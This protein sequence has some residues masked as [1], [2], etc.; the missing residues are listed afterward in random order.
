MRVLLI[1]LLAAISYAQT[2]NKRVRDIRLLPAGIPKDM[3]R[4]E[5]TAMV[6]AGLDLNKLKFPETQIASE[7]EW[8]YKPSALKLART[9]AIHTK[10]G[11]YPLG[12]NQEEL[13]MWGWLRQNGYVHGGKQQRLLSKPHKQQQY[14]GGYGGGYPF[15]GGKEMEY[16]DILPYISQITGGRGRFNY[17]I[18]MEEEQLPFYYSSLINQ[19]TS[20]ASSSNGSSTVTTGTY[21]TPGYGGAATGTGAASGAMNPQTMM[22]TAKWSGEDWK[23]YNAYLH[24]MAIDGVD[25]GELAQYQQ[26]AAMTGHDISR[27]PQTVGYGGMFNTFAGAATNAFAG[28][29]SSGAFSGAASSTGGVASGFNTPG[30]AGIPNI[31][32]SVINNLPP[33]TIN[34]AQAY[35]PMLFMEPEDQAQYYAY[36]RGM[37]NS[38]MDQEELIRYAQINQMSGGNPVHFRNYPGYSPYSAA[39]QRSKAEPKL[40]RPHV[41]E[42]QQQMPY[43]GEMEGEDAIPYLIAANA[44]RNKP[45]ATAAVVDGVETSAQD[46]PENAFVDTS[47]TNTQSGGMNPAMM[48]MMMNGES[49]IGEGDVNPMMM[50]QIMN[51]WQQGNAAGA[52][53]MAMPL[54]SLLFGDGI[55]EEMLPMIMMAAQGAMGGSGNMGSMLPAMLFDGEDMQQYVQ[56]IHGM[57]TP[58]MDA[59]EIQRYAMMAQQQGIKIPTAA[60]AGGVPSFSG[61]QLNPAMLLDGEKAREY[62]MFINGIMTSNMDPSEI[63]QYQQ[64]ARATGVTPKSFSYMP[65]DMAGRLM[66]MKQAKAAEKK[67][68]LLSKPRYTPQKG[69]YRQMPMRR[70]QKKMSDIMEDLYED[71]KMMRGPNGKMQMYSSMDSDAYVNAVMM[72]LD[73]AKLPLPK[74]GFELEDMANLYMMEKQ[75]VSSNSSATPRFQFPS[76]MFGDFGEFEME[77]MM[78]YGGMMNQPGFMQDVTN[79]FQQYMPQMSTG[80]GYQGMAGMGMGDASDMFED[81]M[82]MK[83]KYMKNQMKTQSMGYG[84]GRGDT[85]RPSYPSMNSVWM[86]SRRKL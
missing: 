76:G 56:Y 57:R 54:L 66:A 60:T 16:E 80:M 77:D 24:G 1:A 75:R 5:L 36:K 68:P 31:D 41:Q 55:D 73:P 10:V 15:Y 17:P 62:N 42:A 39:L 64:I 74:E 47:A 29:Q 63:A 14:T 2:V 35:L 86:P 70:K 8:L 38:N 79:A 43:M 85:G 23:Q 82:D 49:G 33:G 25:T 69:N 19:Y 50:Q 72:G 45:A 59:S 28:A 30:S 12:N 21:T 32:P 37:Y 67:T 3:P 58:D 13:K 53:S 27:L 51:A 61:S 48:A 7:D 83:K 18:G 46:A 81:I 84:S 34:Q 20:G 11:E 44:A 4:H 78:K 71:A 40:A 22:I 65:T 6:A 52:A 9:R 26:V